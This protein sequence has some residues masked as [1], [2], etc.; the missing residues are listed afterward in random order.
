MRITLV[1]SSVS[2]HR[3]D[4][5]Q[6]LTT[7]LLN[8]TVAIDAGCLGLMG[9]LDAQVRVTD[10]VLTHGHLDHVAALPVFLDNTYKMRPEPVMVHASRDTLETLETQILTR[11]T[12]MD[13]EMMLKTDPP[14][15]RVTTLEDGRSFEAGGL[16]ITPFRVDH[17]VPSFGLVIEE[18]GATVLFSSDTGPTEELWRR[19]NAAVNLEAVFLEAS[20]PNALAH[21]AERAW[22]LTPAAF[23]SEVGK[24]KRP[25]TVVAIHIKPRFFDEVTR[26]LN[27][28]KLPDLVV[29]RAGE[30]LT[31]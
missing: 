29:G 24:L 6:F 11:R 9:D 13:L 20:M 25:A 30:T 1:P 27:S 7:Y 2:P 23:A 17:A 21:I 14:F 28:L 26:E 3:G 18:H 16:R 8:D 5:W 4:G 22:H 12:W 19:A 15:L 31:F 10:V